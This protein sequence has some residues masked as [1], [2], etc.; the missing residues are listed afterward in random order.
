MIE[1]N[2]QMEGETFLAAQREIF[3]ME[4]FSCVLFCRTT[5]DCGSSVHSNRPHFLG[6][7]YM[8]LSGAKD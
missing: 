4:H 5:V 1:L 8:S 6:Y 3:L 2:V 7:L